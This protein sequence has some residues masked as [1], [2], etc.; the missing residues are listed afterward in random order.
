MSLQQNSNAASAGSS[1]KSS[2]SSNSGQTA[3]ATPTVSRG[4]GRPSF[5][6]TL[7]MAAAAAN[8]ENGNA[9]AAA[10]E[11]ELKQCRIQRLGS[12]CAITKLCSSFGA[13]LM[14][15]IPVF[16]QILYGKISQFLANHGNMLELCL[17]PLDQQQCNDLITSLQLLEVAAP[18]MNVA[19]HE[20]LFV[21]MLPQLGVLITH[22][23]KAVSNF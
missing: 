9:A 17:T 18:H 13:D 22:P 15:K 5:S 3:A 16:E 2:N 7:A 21:D 6:E 11:Q 8:T 19:L 4:P 10:K 23:L 12:C 20:R 1:S 14:H